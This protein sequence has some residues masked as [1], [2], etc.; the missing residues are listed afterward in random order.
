MKMET[1]KIVQTVNNGTC[2]VLKEIFKNKDNK[3]GFSFL[4]EKMIAANSKLEQSY[5]KD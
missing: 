2:H 3:E 5:V 4:V 1:D